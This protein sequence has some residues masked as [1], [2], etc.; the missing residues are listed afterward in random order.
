MMTLLM[1]FLV[2]LPFA[3]LVVFMVG[4]LTYLDE[5]ES[6]PDALR[7]PL[8]QAD[9]YIRRHRQK[10]APFMHQKQTSRE[11]EVH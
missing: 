4:V 7:W 1:V 9:D 8:T 11:E 10:W 2:C 5:D 3:A 6:W